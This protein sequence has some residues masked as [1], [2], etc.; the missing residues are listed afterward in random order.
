MRIYLNEYNILLHNT[1]YLPYSTALL[2][3][4]AQEQRRLKDVCEFMPIIYARQEVGA[5]VKMYDNPRVAAFSVSIW[6]EQ[7]SLAVA[8]KIKAEFPD[9][10]I[11]FG[12]SAVP[13]FPEEYFSKY[14]FIDVTVRGEGERA[15]SAVLE[16]YLDSRDF[17]GIG[18]VSYRDPKTGR[19]VR[20][21]NIYPP[22]PGGDLDIFPSPYLDGVFSPLMAGGLKWQ[23]ILETNR[24]CPFLC[25]Y[26][27]WGQG[28]LS[29]KVSFFGLER[30]RREIEWCGRHNIDY[31][32]C[33]DGNFG[34]FERDLQIAGFL[35]EAKAK[36][37]FPDK[38]RVNYSKTT[39]DRVI[40][41]ASVLHK[42]K[43]EKSITMS[44]QSYSEI[45]LSNVR[46]KNIKNETFRTLQDRFKEA[47]IST[48]TELILGLPGETYRSWADGIDT[49]LRSGI[50][51][52]IFVYLLQIYPNTEMARPDYQKK[53]GLRFVRVPLNEGHGAVRAAD[54]PPEY[55]DV[56]IS[57]DYMPLED[58]KR[59]A[60]FSWLAQAMAGLKLGYFMLIYAVDRYGV[61]HID[62]LEY[63]AAKK[64]PAE[65]AFLRGLMDWLYSLADSIAAG[66]ART[67]ILEDFGNIYW[68][69][70]EAFY[71]RAMEGKDD[72]YADMLIAF[73][74]F[75]KGVKPGF[76]AAEAEEIVKY[77][78]LRVPELGKLKPERALFEYNVPE[79]FE[80]YFSPDKCSLRRS[81]AAADLY[82]AKDFNGD[83]KTF[84]REM[85]LFG[86]KSNRMLYPVKWSARPQLTGGK[87]Q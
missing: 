77:Q 40:K 31:V 42:N 35:V 29:R 2:Q 82:E 58:W 68:E 36:Y 37:G 22:V 26:C 72:F 85:I 86:R 11:V 19:C 46:R 28:G 76:D 23:A 14:S 83:K 15:F 24:G 17:G 66:K 34:M 13:F 80:K 74:D 67:L 6:N 78:R 79:Y 4:Y 20:N 62:F 71:L 33:A 38:F 18:N 45:A 9:C 84:A 60:M 8:A 7:L 10:L 70:E 12:G 39:D 41:V 65:C 55:E 49:C 61:R 57:S 25:A 64:M 32:F 87:V 56:V 21:D 53:Y 47:D 30:V 75:L 3:A 1:A 54:I 52:D 5:I 51:N 59:S 43:L 81:A 27:F 69:F 50:N 63:L 73:K 48:Y 16:R 44:L